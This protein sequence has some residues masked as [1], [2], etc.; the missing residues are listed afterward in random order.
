M[1]REQIRKRERERERGE[2]CI[3]LFASPTRMLVKPSNKKSLQRNDPIKWANE[4][5]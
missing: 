4:I 3:Y 5:Q 2:R 1:K